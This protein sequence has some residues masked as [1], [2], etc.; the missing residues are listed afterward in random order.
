MKKIIL[1]ILSFLVF[2]TNSQAKVVKYNFDIDTKNVNFTGKDINA[3]AINKQ[4]PGPTIEATVGDTLEVTVNNKMNQETSIHWHGVLLPNNQDGVPYLTTNPI[5]PHSSFTYRYDI[6]HSGTYWYHSHT[7]LQEQRG[8]YGSMVLHPKNGEIIKSN[9]DYVVVLSDWTNEDP[10]QVLANLKKDGDYYALKKGSVQSWDGVLKNG[11]GAIKSRLKSSWARMGTMDLSDV[12]Y[13]AFLANGQRE[14]FLEAKPGEVVR[15]RLI[16]SGASTYF[17]VEFA[18]GPMTIIASDGMDVDPIKVKRL[19]IAIAETYDV[20]VKVPDNK[21]YEL[22]AT[23]NDG[24]GKASV[25]IGDGKKVLAPDIPKPNLFLLSSGMKKMSGSSMDH[26]THNM[27]K[28]IIL[29]T[30]LIDYM[31]DYKSLRSVK[32]TTLSKPFTREV[33][34]NL[35]GNMDKYVWHFN[36]KIFLESDKI[37]IKK[38]EVVRFVLTNKTMMPHPIHLHGHFFRVLNGHGNRSPLKHTLNIAP[39]EKVIIEFE[40][41]EE[42]DWFFHCHNLYHMKGGMARV[43][44]YE[45][46]T[47]ATSKT[48]S[49]LAHDSWYFSNDISILSNMNAASLKASNTNNSIEIEYDA[50]YKSQYNVDM[51]YSRNFTRFFD[52]YAGMNVDREEKKEKYEVIAGV[53]Y[54]LPMLIESNLRINTKGKIE[55]RIESDLQLTERSKFEWEWNTNKE[56]NLGI[57]YEINKLFLLKVAYNSDYKWGAGV[58]IKL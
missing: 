48:F 2:A 19:S 26:S 11:S 30:V 56:Y 29:Q 21:S 32:D 10:N 58:R 17:N 45:E 44:S 36:K 28:K 20:L 14:S 47:T 7:G 51:I 22:R 25:F 33:V 50:N 37:L 18:E 43:I 34:L 6:T 1:T 5:A 4:I 55:V 38:G 40:A 49:Q 57:S 12:G 9:R 46:T 31:K 42:K 41:S 27:T 3:I 54:V 15:I 24:T 16:N 23:A 53:R 52:V 35:T 13:D 39:M 8:V